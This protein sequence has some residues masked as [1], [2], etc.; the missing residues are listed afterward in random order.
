MIVS[1]IASLVVYTPYWVAAATTTDN[2]ATATGGSSTASPTK[3]HSAKSSSFSF[4]GAFVL[5]TALISALG[6]W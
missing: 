6:V 5:A 1:T 3:N 2:A 4:R